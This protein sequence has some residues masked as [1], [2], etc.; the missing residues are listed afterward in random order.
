MRSMDDADGPLV[1][2]HVYKALFDGTGMFDPDAIPYAL[3]AATRELRQSG[4][5]S[6]RWATYIHMGI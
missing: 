1:A 6:T 3:D 4:A 2:R 5:R